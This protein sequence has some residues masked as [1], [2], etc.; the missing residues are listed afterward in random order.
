MSS[1]G[2]AQ[3]E[4]SRAEDIQQEIWSRSLAASKNDSTQNAVR[5]LMPAINEMVD[6]TTAR[7]IAANTR[8]PTLI[9]LLLVSVAL[10]SGLLAGY[11][12]A[13]RKSRSWLHML[14]YAAGI[15][16][17][18]YAVLDFE[19]PRSGLIRVDAADKALIQLRDSIR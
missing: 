13:K 2:A 6:V 15:P 1:S 19:D 5:L 16:I 14:L 9:F 7:M 12:M 4:F 10:L 8:L 11:A 3:Q 17:T 18:I